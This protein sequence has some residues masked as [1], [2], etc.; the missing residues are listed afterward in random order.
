MMLCPNCGSPDVRE[1]VRHRFTPRGTVYYVDLW[2]VDCGA[3]VS[4]DL[5][6]GV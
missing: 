6:G 5:E 3:L 1:V 4:E 2:C